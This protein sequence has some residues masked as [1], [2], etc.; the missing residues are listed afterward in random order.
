VL[1]AE[2]NGLND[3]DRRGTD[4][5]LSTGWFVYFSNISIALRILNDRSCR[6]S[7]IHWIKNILCVNSANVY[8]LINSVTVIKLI[9][10][11]T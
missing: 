10:T 6:S 11:I 1:I 7:K 3:L 5:E 9:F 2:F 8:W 4:R